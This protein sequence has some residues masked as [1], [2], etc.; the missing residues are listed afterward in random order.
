MTTDGRYRIFLCNLFANKI[1]R[2]GTKYSREDQY[3]WLIRLAAKHSPDALLDVSYPIH[4]PDWDPH[5]RPHCPSC[6]E[7]PPNVNN[8]YANT[9]LDERSLGNRNAVKYLAQNPQ[10]CSSWYT[11]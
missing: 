4:C 9:Y 2:S 6:P 5:N 11:S 10:T 8:Y 1:K 3:L 7:C